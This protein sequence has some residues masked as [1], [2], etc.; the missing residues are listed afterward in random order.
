LRVIEIIAPEALAAITTPG[1]SPAWAET[2]L[3]GRSRLGLDR[4]RLVFVL[5]VHG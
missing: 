4:R 2:A 3:L 5:F 1:I